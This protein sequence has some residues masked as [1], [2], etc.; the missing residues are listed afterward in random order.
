MVRLV[1]LWIWEKGYSQVGEVELA[2]DGSFYRDWE[3]IGR[4]HV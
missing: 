3:T 4:A 1:G 2:W